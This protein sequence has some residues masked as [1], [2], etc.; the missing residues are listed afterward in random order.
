MK[1]SPSF[2]ITLYYITGG[3]TVMLC[4]INVYFASKAKTSI[5]HTY[6]L[7]Q[8]GKLRESSM[9]NVGWLGK[10][11]PLLDAL[12]LLPSFVARLMYWAKYLPWLGFITADVISF[13]KILVLYQ[14]CNWQSS[15]NKSINCINLFHCVCALLSLFSPPVALRPNA[16]HG[17][18]ILEVSR[19]HTTTHHSR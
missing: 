17:L 14:G 2:W 5:G 7:F 18:L 9:F 10:E 16:G 11:G 12:H 19:S 15:D 6:I 1:L 3:T 4:F 8:I 13:I